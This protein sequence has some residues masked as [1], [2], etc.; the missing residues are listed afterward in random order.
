MAAIIR[1]LPLSATR[2][3]SPR[4]FGILFIKIF[5]QKFLGATLAADNL[6]TFAELVPGIERLTA[7]TFSCHIDNEPVVHVA[8][9]GVA[10]GT[11]TRNLHANWHQAPS[12]IMLLRSTPPAVVLSA[13]FRSANVM[14]G[15][16]T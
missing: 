16:V 7:E 6:I 4:F 1:T 9:Q 10:S 2:T 3:K 15:S 12:L 11:I 5:L 8:T 14:T 13:L